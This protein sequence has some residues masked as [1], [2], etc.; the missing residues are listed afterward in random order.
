MA[1][2]AYHCKF[3]QRPGTAVYDPA[4]DTLR[5]EIW[6]KIL[7]C[8]HCSDF[9]VSRR[10]IDYRISSVCRAVFVARNQGNKAVRDIEAVAWD[11]LEVLTKDLSRMCCAFVGVTNVWDKEF[12]VLLMERPELSQRITNDY[13][14]RLKRA[15]A[16]AIT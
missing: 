6:S 14:A 4:C 15:K 2:I 12:I 9:M 1:T 5:L 13:F 8:N 10:S 7:S 11:K 16:K 3:C